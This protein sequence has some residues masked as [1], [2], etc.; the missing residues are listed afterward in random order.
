MRDFCTLD[1]QGRSFAIAFEQLR[2]VIEPPLLTRIPLAPPGIF[3]VANL[4]GELLPVL[5]VDPL[6][7]LAT[8][9]TTLARRPWMGVF[10]AD[11]FI[12]GILADGVGT[13]RKVQ[14]ESPDAGA[15]N[16][17][18]LEG[19]VAIAEPKP[20]VLNLSSTLRQLSEGL[21][22]AAVLA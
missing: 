5:A 3:G 18:L 21:R 15:G 14:V 2:E 12:V 22:Q 6:L 19:V 13:L 17:P 8:P 1:L 20:V 4:R 16:H 10:E 9:E 7:G 11:S